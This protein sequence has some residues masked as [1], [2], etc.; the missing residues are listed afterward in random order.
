[1]LKARF[2]VVILFLVMSGLASAQIKDLAKDL[3]VDEPSPSAEN[4]YR[5]PK[6]ARRGGGADETNF[7]WCRH[8]TFGAHEDI[9][10]CTLFSAE[11]FVTVDGTYRLELDASASEKNGKKTLSDS[12]IAEQ[13]YDSG[14]IEG[15]YLGRSG[16]FIPDGEVNV[17]THGNSPINFFFEKGKLIELRSNSKILFKASSPKAS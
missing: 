11:G 12:Q 6:D 5:I 1:M 3:A 4:K 16:K 13:G 10:R 17:L 9:F 8:R 7:Y 15:I 14:A 2:I